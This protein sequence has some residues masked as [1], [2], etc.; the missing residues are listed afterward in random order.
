MDLRIVARISVI[1]A[2]VFAYPNV[3]A[4]ESNLKIE[5]RSYFPKEFHFMSLRQTV[6][7]LLTPCHPSE[8]AGG[9]DR[10]LIRALESARRQ[11][12]D[13]LLEHTLDEEYIPVRREPRRDSYSSRTVFVDP[14]ARGT[15]H[16]SLEGLP[17]GF[18][19]EVDLDEELTF[20]ISKS[21]GFAKETAYIIQIWDWNDHNPESRGKHCGFTSHY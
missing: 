18:S 13:A 16:L 20:R 12:A 4:S 1:I 14:F 19:V 9:W 2:F 11:L 17:Q 8:T 10:E 21:G 5:I 6:A 3:G 15:S 7:D